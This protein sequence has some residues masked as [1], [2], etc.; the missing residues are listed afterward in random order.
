MEEAEGV[1]HAE[2]RRG[3]PPRCR[4]DGNRRRGWQS[5]RQCAR[6]GLELQ[7][8]APE[9]LSSGVVPAC[10]EEE[11]EEELVVVMTVVAF[12]VTVIG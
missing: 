5:R 4:G 1:A 7:M 9:A 8:D 10:M 2:G 11:E 3:Q 12:M 6:L